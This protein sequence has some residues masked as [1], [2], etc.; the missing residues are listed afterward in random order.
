MQEKGVAAPVGAVALT[1][2]AHASADGEALEAEWVAV[3]QPAAARYT[4]PA[5]FTSADVLRLLGVV[6][7]DEQVPIAA[8]GRGRCAAGPLTSSA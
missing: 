1:G 5:D 2:A 7:C 8:V 3:G 4:L 6:P